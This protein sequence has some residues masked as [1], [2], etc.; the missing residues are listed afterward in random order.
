MNRG[1]S[2]KGEVDGQVFGYIYNDE[3]S[4]SARCL[5][6][7]YIENY[8]TCWLP[9]W[10]EVPPNPSPHSAPTPIPNVLSNNHTSLFMYCILQVAWLSVMLTT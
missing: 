2:G 6:E 8:F 7:T 3:T 4:E 5:G 9:R 10:K 1:K